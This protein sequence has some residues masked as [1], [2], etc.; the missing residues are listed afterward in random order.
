MRK[1]GPYMV[2][3]TMTSTTSA[4]LATPLKIKGVNYSI[5]SACSTS[6]H[7]IGHAAELIQWN[8]QDLMLAGGGEEVHWSTTVLFDR[9]G[10]AVVQL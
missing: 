6:A 8:K 1:V 3:R 7:C 4:C 9:D 2:T 5:G 10:R